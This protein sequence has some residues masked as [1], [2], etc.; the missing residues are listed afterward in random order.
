MEQPGQLSDREWEVAKLLLEGKS[1]KLIAAALQIS[2]R[3]VEF[4]LKNIYAKYQVSSRVELILKLGESTGSGKPVESTVESKEEIKEN[5]DRLILSNLSTSLR[6]A[7]SRIGKEL[8]MNTVMNTNASSEGN[9]MTFFESIR[10]CLRKYAEFNGQ[11]SRAEFWWFTL[12]VTL[13]ASALSYVSQ[14]LAIV[15]GFAFLLPF[16]AVGARRCHDVGRSG[17]W[18]LFYLV[19]AAGPFLVGIVMVMPSK[20]PVSGDSHQA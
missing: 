3:T 20:S 12:F 6:A 2:E 14:S 11:A 17:W 1:N 15:F 16:L 13:A 10:V 4:H 7:V 9:T 8:K 18:Q 19:P 5:R